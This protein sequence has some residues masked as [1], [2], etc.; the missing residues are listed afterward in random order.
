MLGIERVGS[1]C[2]CW[3][4]TFECLVRGKTANLNA[5]PRSN[6]QWIIQ[7]WKKMKIGFSFMCVQ[8]VDK[9]HFCWVMIFKVILLLLSSL[10]CQSEDH[11]KLQWPSNCWTISVSYFL[12]DLRHEWFQGKSFLNSNYYFFNSRIDATAF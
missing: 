5:F 2:N 6:H 8:E 1:K 7:K 9:N 10:F 12:G 11:F 3:R 4:K